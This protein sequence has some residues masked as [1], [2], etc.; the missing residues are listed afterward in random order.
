[1]PEITE[2]EARQASLIRERN[3]WEKRE[4]ELRSVLPLPGCEPFVKR[5]LIKCKEEIRRINEILNS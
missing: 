5:N 3:M 2:K 1:M 4:K